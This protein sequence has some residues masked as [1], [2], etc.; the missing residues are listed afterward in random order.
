VTGS[1]EEWQ[2]PVASF[3][4]VASFTAWHWIDPELRMTKAADALRSGGTEEFFVRA[5]EC[6][7]QWDP[8]TPPGLRLQPAAKIWPQR[9]RV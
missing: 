9:G 6:Y 2:F 3:D 7:E 1:F 5:Q 4:L 8:K